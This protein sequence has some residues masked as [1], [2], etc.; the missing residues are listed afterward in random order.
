MHFTRLV[1]E[2]ALL[3]CGGDCHASIGARNNNFIVGGDRHVMLRI[4]RDD[5]TMGGDC[6]APIDARL[7]L[8]LTR[9]GG[10]WRGKCIF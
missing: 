8:S 10:A 5:M 7:S 9:L 3:V 6:H 4:P 2:E 1:G